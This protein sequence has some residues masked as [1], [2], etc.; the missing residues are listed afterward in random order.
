M[1][2]D[3]AQ[4]AR[5]YT[6]AWQVTRRP[7]GTRGSRARPLDYLLARCSDPEGGFFSSQDAD[8]EGVEGK[9]FVWT[10]GRARARW[11]ASRWRH[12]SAPRR[13]GTGR[14]DER[15]VA[16]GATSPRSPRR[17][18]DADELAAAVG[19]RAAELFDVAR[20][21]RAPGHRRQGA[22]GLERAWRSGRS[23]RRAACWTSRVPRGRARARTSCSRELRDEDGRLLRR[24]GDGRPGGPGSLDDHALMA[25][26]LPH[27]LRDH[28]RARAGSRRRAR[29]PTTCSTGSATRS[30]AASSRPARTREALVVRPKDLYD[31][32]APGGNSAAAE[33]CCGSR[34]SRARRGTRSRGVGPAPVRARSLARPR[35][36]FGHALCALDLYLGPCTRS[37]SSAI[38]DAGDRGAGARGDGRG[39]PPERRVGGGR[40]G[41]RRR[42]RGRAAAA[43]PRGGRRTPTAYVCERFACRLPVTDREA[44]AA[45]LA[46]R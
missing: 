23:P 1:L 18:L 40:A 39:V 25:V 37:R 19:G 38:P 28:V 32:A 29:W 11:S 6:R 16:S 8:T 30:A 15:P 5:L 33:C 7:S 9:F 4:L 46:A 42:G 12:A 45:Q 41:R 31:N 24:G 21:A 26:G 3:N 22:R 36:A 35:T 14:G 44:L 27:P 13:R 2:Y 17:R 10:L 20:A 43:R 34:C